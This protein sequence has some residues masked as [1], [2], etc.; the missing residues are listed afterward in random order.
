MLIVF[1]VE[2]EMIMTQML[3][4]YPALIQQGEKQLVRY[5]G[6]HY[7]LTPYIT[8]TQTTTVTLP[9]PNIETYSRLKPTTHT[10]TSVTY[11]S[12]E[13]VA[14]FSVVSLGLLLIDF[15]HLYN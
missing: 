6:N 15:Q 7:V 3:E 13:G 2:A 8:T 11:G 9:S 12:Y 4:P 14:G 5:T 1:Q 10:D